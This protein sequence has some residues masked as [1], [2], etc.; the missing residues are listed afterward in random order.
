MRAALVIFLLG[1]GSCSRPPSGSV[2]IEAAKGGTVSSADGAFVLEVPPNALKA[3][4]AVSVRLLDEASWPAEVRSAAP[5]G[6]VWELEPDGLVFDPPA[7]ATTKLPVA[8]PGMITP[9]EIAFLQHRMRS[10]G[11]PVESATTRTIIEADGSVTI[12]AELPHASQQWTSFGGVSIGHGPLGGQHEVE[13]TW[14][15]APL[16]LL[17][18]SETQINGYALRSIVDSTVSD[19]PIVPLHPGWQTSLSFAGRFTL[20]ATQD[21]PGVVTLSADAGFSIPEPVPGWLCVE[22]GTANTTASIVLDSFRDAGSLELLL[23]IT[24]AFCVEKGGTV[25]PRGSPYTRECAKLPFEFTP[26]QGRQGELGVL[27]L[28][29][30][31]GCFFTN[32]VRVDQPP[33]ISQCVTEHRAMVVTH[34]GTQGTANAHADWGYAYATSG[35]DLTRKSTN[36]RDSVAETLVLHSVSDGGRWRADFA[37]DA[38]AI[39]VAAVTRFTGVL[40]QYG[41]VWDAADTPRTFSSAIA[42]GQAQVYVRIC[43]ETTGLY[44]HGDVDATPENDSCRAG[45]Y[46]AALLVNST[47]AV[48]DATHPSVTDTYTVVSTSAGTMATD[49]VTGIP[50]GVDV[51]TVIAGPLGQAR[52]AYRYTGSGFIVQSATLQ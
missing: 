26:V 47:G 15:I 27:C 9:G 46:A 37:M 25:P 39:R 14:N 31:G 13:E 28:P 8:P 44:L 30:D 3:D 36:P 4:T 52:L 45:H 33:T 22:P 11:G 41:A 24:T 38:G 5:V 48:L 17:A 49:S 50:A 43:W 51:T 42:V 20:A 2:L 29:P 7:R 12:V 21:R 19:S 18:A 6:P 40:P 34:S 35:V 16:T 32:D 10:K 1:L 23:P